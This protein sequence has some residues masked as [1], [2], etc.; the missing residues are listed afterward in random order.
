MKA[1]P[2]RQGLYLPAFEHDSCGADRRGASGAKTLREIPGSEEFR[3]AGAV[4][5][6]L[7]FT[8]AEKGVLIDALAALNDNFFRY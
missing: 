1:K 8:G 7:G 6:A 5:L 3:Q 4:F 2:K